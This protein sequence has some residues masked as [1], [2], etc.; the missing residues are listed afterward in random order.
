MKISRGQEIYNIPVC[1]MFEGFILIYGTMYAEKWIWPTF[2]SKVGQ[3]DLITTK[4]KFCRLRG[5]P[6]I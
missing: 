1:T 6:N 5:L 3:S 2:E 4:L